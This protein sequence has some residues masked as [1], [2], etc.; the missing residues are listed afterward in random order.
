MKDSHNKQLQATLGGNEKYAHN[1]QVQST[2]AVVQ[3]TLPPNPSKGKALVKNNGKQASGGSK[4]GSF[5]KAKK[6]GSK[7]KADA[8]SPYARTRLT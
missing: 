7:E 4:P 5:G 1:R 6:K 2:L 3:S 8:P